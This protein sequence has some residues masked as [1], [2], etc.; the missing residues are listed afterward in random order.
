MKT[1]A[2][3]FALLASIAAPFATWAQGTAPDFTVTDINGDG[4]VAASDLLAFL[5]QFGQTCN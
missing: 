5:G 3:C 1:F 4:V 2:L